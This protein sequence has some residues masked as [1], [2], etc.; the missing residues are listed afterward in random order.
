MNRRALLGRLAAGVVIAGTGAGAAAARQSSRSLKD[1]VADAER[2]FADS[3]AK[4]DLAT[5]TA[6]LSQEA[7]FFGGPD[8]NTPT[9]GRTAIVQ[10]WKGFFE[11]PTAPFSWTPDTSEVI[12]SGTLG[13][14]SGP[15][16]NANGEVTGRFNSV[17]RLESDG[18]WRVVFDK[19]CRGCR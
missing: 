6:R 16:R 12:D 19:G 10:A 17:W 8:G 3:M 2:A 4:R 14:T 1:A 7:I 9:R 18:Q 13:I 11:G 5:F 15:V